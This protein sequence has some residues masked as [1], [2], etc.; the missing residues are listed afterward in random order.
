MFILIINR[1]I[2]GE[3]WRGFAYNIVLSSECDE[4]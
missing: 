1:Q 3:A 4:F 2:N